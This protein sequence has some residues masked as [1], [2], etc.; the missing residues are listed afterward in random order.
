MLAAVG[1]MTDR[2]FSHSNGA[3]KIICVLSN[4]MTVG[5]QLI[6]CLGDQQRWGAAGV[7]VVALGAIAGGQGSVDMGLGRLVQ[8]TAFAQVPALTGQAKCMLLCVHGFMAGLA[9]SQFNGGMD[10]VFL[11]IVCMAALGTT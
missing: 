11:T 1:F 5:T 6:D 9:V 7:G 2:A 10:M 3:V 4:F 8:M